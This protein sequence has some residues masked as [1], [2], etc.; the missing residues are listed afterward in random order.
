MKFLFCK[1]IYIVITYIC[2][3]G[4][5]IQLYRLFQFWFSK[6]LLFSQ[7][8]TWIIAVCGYFILHFWRK[9]L[10]PSVME[11]CVSSMK[12]AK[13]RNNGPLIMVRY[14][15]LLMVEKLI[16]AKVK[17]KYST[18]NNLQIAVILHLVYEVN[19]MIHIFGVSIFFEFITI[20]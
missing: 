7:R 17:L 18:S 14:G 20:F 10:I 3:N 19:F 12:T 8:I 13:T 2:T 15:F 11:Y 5:S 1:Y 9:P 16:A 6:N 4:I